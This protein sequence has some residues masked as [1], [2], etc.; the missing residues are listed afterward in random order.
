MSEFTDI[1]WQAYLVNFLFWA[2][3]AQ[4]AVILVATL[5]ITNAGW[6]KSYV[7][8]AR[9]A[10]GFLPVCVV[11]FAVLLLGRNHLFEWIIE[12]IPEKA[13]YLNVRF[14]AIRGLVGLS[15]MAALSWILLK[16]RTADVIGAR[17]PGDAAQA[18]A[19]P[20]SVVVIIAFMGVYS[21][22][23][24]DL[25]MSLKPHW[26]STLLG[27]HFAVSSFYLG[28]AG[29]CFIGG[30]GADVPGEDS[31]KLCTLMFGVSPFWISLLWSQYIVI[32]YGDMP[33]E[34]EFLYLRFYQ[35]PWQ[36]VTLVMLALAFVL[37]FAILIARRTK[38]MKSVRMLAS[39]SAIA[40]LFLE[41]YIL[42][43]PSLSPYKPRGLWIYLLVTA[44]FAVLFIICYKFTMRRAGPENLPP[45][46]TSSQPES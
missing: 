26:Y 25:I 46:P 14:L 12:P 41:K 7:R 20:W 9:A 31:R 38:E 2:G 23:A 19:S 36:A 44:G 3:L 4:G 45:S 29:L 39:L 15:V 16:G 28:I 1:F 10:A 42:V 35:M 30:R 22:L 18:G 13:A 8:V 11:L 21:V 24:F 6:G 27:A 32:W 37:P 43:A 33:E 34:T 40:G 17:Q 5:D